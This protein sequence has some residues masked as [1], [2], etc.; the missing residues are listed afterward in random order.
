VKHCQAPSP[1]QT[2][3][4]N[5]GRV[6]G[7]L[8]AAWLIS[9]TGSE[10]SVFLANGISFVFVIVGVF[11][12]RT[13]FKVEDRSVKITGHGQR[14][15]TRSRIYIRQNAVVVIRHLDVCALLGFF[16]IPLLQQTPCA[17]A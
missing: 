11:F 7:P 8:T 15:Q 12:A 10:G 3:A 2:T 1:L 6:L 17:C 16:G 5:L 4:F 14:I 13:R 9:L